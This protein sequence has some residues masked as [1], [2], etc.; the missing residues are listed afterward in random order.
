M[1]TWEYC[2]LSEIWITNPFSTKLEVHFPDPAEQ[3]DFLAEG[4]KLTD[5]IN[6]L[7]RMGWEAVNLDA[8]SVE[9]GTITK[10][11]FKRETS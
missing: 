4:M 2:M 10:V 1:K 3:A 8:E 6:H 11:L 7:G 5:A 9:N